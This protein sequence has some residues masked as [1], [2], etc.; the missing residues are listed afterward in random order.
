MGGGKVRHNGGSSRLV[1][2]RVVGGRNSICVTL[3]NARRVHTVR[4]E[5][6]DSAH[7]HQ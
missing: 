5:D 2:A 3:F 1:N 4:G 6:E 7:L